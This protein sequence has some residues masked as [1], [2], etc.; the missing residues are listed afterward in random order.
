MF[1]FVIAASVIAAFGACGPGSGEAYISELA[2]SAGRVTIV[3]CGPIGQKPRVRREIG[4]G[5][6]ILEQDG[7]GNHVSITQRNFDAN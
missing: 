7:T 6:S 4:P 5:Y 1:T 2:T 3:Q